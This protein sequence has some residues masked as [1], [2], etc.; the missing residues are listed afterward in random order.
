MSL[1]A[2][3]SRAAPLAVANVVTLLVG[4]VP[5]RARADEHAEQFQGREH[6][7]ENHPTH[8]SRPATEERV[9]Q[10]R[11]GV[12]VT[13]NRSVDLGPLESGGGSEALPTGGAR[14]EVGSES[15]SLP[16]GAGTVLGMGESF[17]TDPSTGIATFR[18]PIALPAAR[19]AAQPN[20]TL[21]YSSA[22]GHGTAGVG[23]DLPI[24]F[25]SRQTDRGV[26]QYN[27]PAVGAAWQPTQDRFV[28]NGGQ[29]LV[30]ICLVSGGS[31]AGSLAGE[32]MP[33]W[34]EGWQYFRPRVEGAFLRFFWSPDH[35]TWRV[36][37]K[38]G[39]SM[40]I[41]VPLDGS[42]D[43][44]GLETD[45]ANTS[46]IFRWNLAREYD[47]QGGANPSGSANPTPNNPVVY[48]YFSI[49]GISYLTDIYD[50]P[51]ASN[52]SIAPTSA[53]AHHAHL[54]YET[55]TDPTLSFRRGW[56]VSDAERLIGIDVASRNFAGD[57]G[58]PR[59]LV[60]RV[61]LAYDPSYHIS[62]L[63][64]VQVEGRCTGTV[65]EDGSQ[66]LPATACPM[67]P[68][69]TLGYQHVAG[70][71]TDGS[72]ASADL[73]GYEAFDERIE[74]MSTS[75]SHSLD[76][77]LTELMDINGDALPD[78]LV[79]APA[80]YGGNDGLY[81]NA[82]GGGLRFSSAFQMGVTG[83]PPEG[84]NDVLLSNANV[85]FLDVDGD[86]LIN[87][88]HMP[89][90]LTY[91]VY[92]P[93]FDGT[94]WSWLGR[95]ITTSSGQSAK[96]DFTH[97]AP[98]TRAMDV[99]GDGL[100]DV[101]FTS[102][103]EVQTFLALGRYPGGDGQYG[104]AT[105]TS[106]SSASISNDP[107]ETCLPWSATAAHFSDPDVRVADMNGD[108]FPDIVR[109]RPGDVRYWP[110]RGNG[111]W[112]TGDPSTCPGDSFG[113]GRD[114]SMAAGPQFGIVE[115]ADLLDLEDVN[116]DGLDDLVKVNFN[117]VDVYLNVDGIGWTGRHII[118]NAPPNGTVTNRVRITDINGS[119]TRDILWGDGNDY[120]YMDLSGGQRPWVLTSAAN[121]LGKTTAITYATSTDQMLAAARAGTPWQ[122]TSPVVSHMVASV[123]TRDNLGVVGH[124]DGA[125]QTSYTYRDP[126][127]DGRQRE[128]RGFR[129]AD[130]I[131]VGDVNS[132]TSTQETTFLLGEC[133][134]EPG[135]P[136]ISPCTPQGLW[137]DNPR[138]ALKGRALTSES[139]DTTGTYLSTS[140]TTYRLRHLYS[141]ADGREVRAAF[142]SQSDSY[143]YDTAS[144]TSAVSTTPT[145][146]VELESSLGAVTTDTTS[147]LTLRS[148]AGRA[149]LHQSAL[150]DAFG[151]ATDRV[152]DGCVDGC[153]AP[154]E[155]ITVHTT[156]SRRGDDTTGWMWRTSESYVSG[157]SA[158]SS[159]R[160]HT[161]VDFDLFG[162]P[163][164]TH[165]VLSGTLPLD[166]FHANPAKTVAPA[167]PNASSDGTILVSSQ[168]YDA[169]GNVTSQ[170]AP[171]GRCAS[172]T[173]DSAYAQLSTM[174][175]T[176]VGEIGSGGCGM[177]A[178]TT[179]TAYDRGLGVVTSTTDVRGE[180]SLV[181][182]DGFGR[183]T[184]AYKPDPN[185]VGSPS[186]VPSLL[187]DYF[188]TANAATT[189]YSRV[190]VQVQDGPD[191]SSAQYRDAWSYID[192]LG[193]KIV[194]LTEADPGAGDG[195]NFIAGGFTTYDAKGAVQ[196]AYL[197]FF[198]NVDASA[199]ALS[200][201]PSTNFERQRYDA[202][203]R[204]VQTFALDGAV[205]SQSFHH[206]LSDDVW[207]AADLSP[208]PH[209]GTPAS[210]RRDGHGRTVSVIER[211]HVGSAI[212][213]HDTQTSYLP[214]GEP[215]TITRVRAG[216]S[217]APVVRWA[218]YDSLGRRVLNVEPDATVNFTA[219]PNADPSTFHAW[220]Y[221]YDDDG[222][223]VGTSDARGCGANY[224]YDAGGRNVAEDYSPCT[225][226]QPDYSIP[227]LIDGSG[228]EVLNSFDTQDPQASSVSGF[229]PSSGLYLGRIAS[230]SDRGA[231]TI[232]AYDGRGRLTQGARRIVKPGTPDDVLA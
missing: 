91:S 86:G 208:G 48:R 69:M 217:D 185:V 30:P 21:S 19:G 147:S 70:F 96:I 173:F 43:V 123:T 222:D 219:N 140:H 184:A 78:V 98:D 157:S 128:F 124:A 171:N 209:Q 46:H 23:W 130:V 51:P 203:G 136:A 144:F 112:G 197:P 146:D 79:T 97:H 133:K 113:Q 55:R 54:N 138:E 213:A 172:A 20:L 181:T 122:S 211:T 204:S 161:F 221:A 116:G 105:W 36:Q 206:A 198:V 165:A 195:G 52:A 8:A 45:P 50:T 111:F 192:G 65:A 135:G 84:P 168:G 188:L 230:I 35:R 215:L 143:L 187:V 18:V 37:S 59:E 102:G 182:Y 99:N 67:L 226:D 200:T 24:A 117:E 41:G 109:L 205:A 145:T 77:T 58:T 175:T 5:Y 152:D 39:T 224:L 225:D 7:A 126:V 40:E 83:V 2:L 12:T 27:D 74:H 120:K 176:N 162:Q 100:V 93:H 68:P 127:Y 154:D 110:G 9:T 156:P 150:V 194:T 164:Q 64:T 73:T 75:P 42:N 72:S 178:L 33:S 4:L 193:R 142:A 191:A 95:A 166:R 153:L 228:V 62:L 134:D 229:A 190:H 89:Q 32:A 179:I 216:A 88:M 129:T 186:S 53:Y 114:I 121:G 63:T 158:P 11:G 169:F 107:I 159:L 180:V 76:E 177:T 31:C 26:P 90:V 155:S 207:D 10:V 118:A 227:D 66:L 106:A 47:A 119:G 231:T 232:P 151:N 87:L 170:T 92:A 189:P 16:Q 223:L 141:G 34:A 1:R 167:P 220:R 202:F 6:I 25:I 44:N 163:L 61:H 60:R 212:E 148:T 38:A 14:N 210:A 218:R 80:L 3:R 183:V 137:E 49:G 132:P 174:Q 125:Y 104:S 15:V 81:L 94:S 17:S 115:S 160:N 196:R 103:T 71:S 57:P 82:S 28:F 108:G 29:E 56:Q 13:A 199:F 214:T 149:H 101:V 85:S 22:S 201:V 131:R 139:F